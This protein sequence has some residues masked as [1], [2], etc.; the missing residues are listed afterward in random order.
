MTSKSNKKKNNFSCLSMYRVAEEEINKNKSLI[1]IEN[2]QKIKVSKEKDQNSINKNSAQTFQ[3]KP[4]NKKNYKHI[5]RI[6][7]DLVSNDNNQINSNYS[8]KEYFLNSYK[9]GTVQ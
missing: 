2:N 1:K 4:A 5:D 3:A 8:E 7:I 6:I 9:T